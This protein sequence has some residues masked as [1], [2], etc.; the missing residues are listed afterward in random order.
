[1][2]QREQVES[3]VGVAARGVEQ[4]G[5]ADAA[6]VGGERELAVERHDERER[7]DQDDVARVE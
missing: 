6:V 3:A 4:G 1:V 2:G 5:V 7:S